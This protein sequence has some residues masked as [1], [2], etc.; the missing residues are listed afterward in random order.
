MTKSR[1]RHG[2]FQVWV[3]LREINADAIMGEAIAS[4]P[5][6]TKFTWGVCCVFFF[7]QRTRHTRDLI[8]KINGA[9]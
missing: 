2:A 3:V 1:D 4:R 6:L 7:L 8:V 9:E 5:I